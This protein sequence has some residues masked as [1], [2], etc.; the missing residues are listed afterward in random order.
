MQ[1]AGTIHAFKSCLSYVITVFESPSIQSLETCYL[2]NGT[3]PTKLCKIDSSDS[4]QPEKTTEA[5]PAWHSSYVTLEK[6]LAEGVP[7][8][9]YRITK[10]KNK[11]GT[12][13]IKQFC[14][15][16]QCYA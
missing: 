1:E 2:E 16:I 14:K 6:R 13:E 15:T 7:D 9:Q 12:L 11:G 10:E 8:E 5:A 4:Y 3:F